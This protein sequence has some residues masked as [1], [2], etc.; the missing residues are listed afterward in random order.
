MFSLK[1]TIPI[2]GSRCAR[3]FLIR[4]RQLSQMRVVIMMMT[5]SENRFLLPMMKSH[6]WDTDDTHRKVEEKPGDGYHATP[7]SS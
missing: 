7:K 4:K 3:K 5:I 1:R 6:A 2:E